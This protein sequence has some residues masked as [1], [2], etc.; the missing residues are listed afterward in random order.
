MDEKERGNMK[1]FLCFLM[2]VCMLM[3]VSLAVMASDDK[4]EISFCV[5]DDT[6]I[7]NGTPV[8]VE[9]PYVVG[10]GV[11]LVP[12]RVITE[13]FDAKVDWID[14]TQTVILTYPDVNI[15][16]QIGNPVAEIN[17]RAETLLAAPELT[18]SGY[19]MVPLRFISENFGADVSYDETTE[20]ITVIKEKKVDSDSSIQGAVTNKYIG[21]SF[22]KWSMENPVD[23]TMDY[24]GFDGLE[25]IFVDDE[26]EIDIDIYTYDSKEFDFENEYNETKLS[27]SDLTLVKMEKN[28]D[29]PKCKSFRLGASDKNY[30]YDYQQY[31]TPDYIYTV[32]A[33]LK[34]D[35]AKTRDN[36]LNILSTFACSFEQ[37]DIYDLSNIKDG[38]RKFE[39]EHLKLSFDVP[40]NFYLA[41]SDDSQNRFEFY[42]LGEG[43]SSV[44]AVIYS[45]DDKVTAKSLATDDYNHNKELL[46]ESITTFNGITEKQYEK[47]LATEYEYTV[48]ASKK[49]YRVR[50]VFFEVG[51]YI[52]NIAVTVAFERTNHEEY[53]DKI[54]NSVVAEP[55]SIEEIGIF[56]KN[57]PEATGTIKATIGKL[58]IEMP[59]V[60]VKVTSNDS[61]LAY[62]GTINGVTVACAKVAAT[63]LETVNDVRM[64]MMD[65][66][67]KMKEEG[68][69]MMN[70][71]YQKVIDEQKFFAFKE[72]TPNDETVVYTEHLV[73]HY[74]D[75]LY[76]IS[77]GCSE[78]V[79][80]TGTKA[81]I[82]KIIEGMTF[83][84]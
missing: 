16:I 18:E 4:V 58:T 28:T 13:A 10:A 42:E 41:S 46:N 57:V 40:E 48:K 20:R 70:P 17:G 55:L 71:V 52:Y 43:V 78:F 26:N 14:E 2:V 38:F 65:S 23:M 34:N 6:L 22:F 66:A 15:V 62:T 74:K 76:V 64:M 80:S 54:I 27:M 8:T 59:N 39:A 21:D 37:E 72:K 81:E 79:H 49:G 1:K 11:T 83:S 31:V 12:V 19:T 30:Y 61:V 50:D 77:I 35:D 68:S 60:Y 25:T 47:M 84:K 73:C 29:N 75:N 7:I 9:K 82:K 32:V 3:S 67:D 53:I 5:G 51:D 36:Y 69:T 33:E 63:N 24:R 45:K 44:T 56:I